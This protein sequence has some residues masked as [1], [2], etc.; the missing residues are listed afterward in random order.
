MESRV[1]SDVRTLL[2][3]WS[4]RNVVKCN[5]IDL[6]FVPLNCEPSYFVI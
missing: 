1:G 2:I 5:G 6:T 3:D 4:K